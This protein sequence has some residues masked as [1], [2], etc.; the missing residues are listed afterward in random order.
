MDE[1]PLGGVD[2]ER[3]GR[4][5]R[6]PEEHQQVRA[7]QKNKIEKDKNDW[8]MSSTQKGSKENAYRGKVWYP[9]ILQGE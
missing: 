8:R 7:G 1:I 9:G 5:R 2:S 3:T 4:A 6:E